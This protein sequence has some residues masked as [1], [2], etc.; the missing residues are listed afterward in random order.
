[1]SIQIEQFFGIKKYMNIKLVKLFRLFFATPY[2]YVQIAYKLEH[3]QG[4]SI[5]Q[6]TQ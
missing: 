4:F 5:I 3:E 1:M 2:N 6:K